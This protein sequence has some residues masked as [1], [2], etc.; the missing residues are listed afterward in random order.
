[1]A[2]AGYGELVLFEQKDRVGRI[3]LNRPEKRNAMSS[4]MQA[5]LR[6]AL[7]AARDCSA[8]ILYGGDG[9]TFCSG[10]DLAENRN[11]D[12]NEPR[13]RSYSVSST[14]WVATLKMIADHPAVCIAAVNGFALGGGTSIISCSDLAIASDRA[15]LGMPEMGFGTFPAPAAPLMSKRVLP[16]HLN[17]LIFMAQR[18]NA[19]DALRMGIVNWVV[20][21]D[22]LLAEAE[23]IAERIAKLDPTLIDWAK[24]GIQ[25]L[26]HVSWEVAPQVAVYVNSTARAQGA[27]S[28]TPGILTGQPG[29]GQGVNQS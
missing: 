26:A 9:N 19:A 1:M 7:D 3:T 15:E 8:V 28:S 4:A 5:E 14:D 20:P 18:V 24:R 25:T 6:A 29:L 27:Q 10:V 12:P 21:H 11:R 16:K 22:S 13:P 17:Q 2:G 23:A